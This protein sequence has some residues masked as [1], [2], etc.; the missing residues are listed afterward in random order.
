MRRVGTWERSNGSRVRVS[1]RVETPAGRLRVTLGN[2][3]KQRVSAANLNT[4][5]TVPR[6]GQ[7]GVSFLKLILCPTTRH[8]G[9]HTT[10]GSK[11]IAATLDPIAVRTGVVP[12][13]VAPRR[14]SPLFPPSAPCGRSCRTC[15]PSPRSLR[16]RVAVRAAWRRGSQQVLRSIPRNLWAI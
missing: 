2:L 3:L 7:V 13:S 11:V 15:R 8:E 9:A 12:A 16:S 1:V 10:S 5:G 6:W 14:A 4:T